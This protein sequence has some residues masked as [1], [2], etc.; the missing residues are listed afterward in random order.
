MVRA[1]LQSG[2]PSPVDGNLDL[3]SDALD[4]LAGFDIQSGEFSLAAGLLSQAEGLDLGITA[5]TLPY[6][7]LRLAAW[8]GQASIVLNL[9]EV[10]TR[11]AQDR[12]EGRGITAAEHAMATIHNGV[13]QY[14]RALDAARRRPRR[15]TSW[16]H[17][18]RCNASRSCWRAST[19]R[20]SRRSHSP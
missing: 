5:E 15:S 4:Y 19:R 9:V 3:A 16:R 11:G 18:G 10:M 12:D 7:P 20:F 1:D 8:R 13:G 14:D 17:H 6:I 2:R